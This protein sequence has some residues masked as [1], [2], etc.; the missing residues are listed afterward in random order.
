M[1]PNSGGRTRPRQNVPNESLNSKDVRNE[2]EEESRD[3]IQP[4]GIANHRPK[5]NTRRNTCDS[6]S[7]RGESSEHISSQ[8]TSMDRISNAEEEDGELKSD[9]KSWKWSKQRSANLYRTEM[10]KECTNIEDIITRKS[11]STAVAS[12]MILTIYGIVD[13]PKLESADLI[14]IFEFMMFG[15]SNM[16]NKEDVFN[17]TSGRWSSSF[18]RKA[19][20]NSIL[21]IQKKI[22]PPDVMKISLDDISNRPEYSWFRKIIPAASYCEEVSKYNEVKGATTRCRKFHLQI[23]QGKRMPNEFEIAEFALNQAYS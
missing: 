10:S 9:K 15:R 21:H 6:R 2:D 7:S 23:G 13:K 20:K 16:Q 11:V 5:R 12:T 14:I 17:T 1:A 22:V 4:N 3:V 19:I 8:I 18:R